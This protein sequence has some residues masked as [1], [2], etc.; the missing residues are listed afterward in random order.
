VLQSDPYDRPNPDMGA[1]S[2]PATA[3]HRA[4]DPNACEA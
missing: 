1:Q 2:R 4:S 3:A